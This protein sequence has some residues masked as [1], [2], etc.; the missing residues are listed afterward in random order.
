MPTIYFHGLAQPSEVQVSIQDHPTINWHDGE[1]AVDIAFTIAIEKSRIQ[2][3]CDLSSFDH[4]RDLVRVYMRAFDLARATI[5]LTCFSTGWGLSVILDRYTNP[6][7]ITTA[8]APHDARLAAL[9][10]AFQMGPAPT[11]GIN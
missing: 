1:T 8:F 9:C 2:V 6:E 10:T 3:K 4:E 11:G 7:G 5:D